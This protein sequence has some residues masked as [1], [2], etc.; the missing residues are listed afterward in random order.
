MATLNI[1]NLPDDLYRRLQARARKEHRSVAQEVTRL[2]EKALEEP[3]PL[4]ILDLAGA[5]GGPMGRDGRG[6]ACRAGAS[7][8]GLMDVVGPG[9]VAVDT[10]VFIYFA[11]QHPEFLPPA[12]L[13]FEAADRGDVEVVTSEITLLEVLVVPYRAGNL[14]LAA[15]YEAI[16]TR[17]RGIRLV[18]LDR[19]QLRAAAQ[20]RAVHGM[21]TPDAL[22]IAAALAANCSAF[23]TN[24]RRMPA[25]PG[26]P[27]VQLSDHL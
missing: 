3:E 1:K 25:L 18:S 21:R 8:V 24:D 22:Q 17:S 10:A 12:R 19:S 26:L 5:R 15:R 6:G 2:L 20:L 13:L 16:L 23:V 9:P 11:E 14:P 7:L 4:S 27:V